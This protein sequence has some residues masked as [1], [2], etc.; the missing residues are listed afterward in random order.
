MRTEF[1]FLFLFP[2]S[3]V[4]LFVRL[5]DFTE[6]WQRHSPPV[7]QTNSLSCFDCFRCPSQFNWLPHP[8]FAQWR[9]RRLGFT[10]KL[11]QIWEQVW[12]ASIPTK[13]AFRSRVTQYNWIRA[14]LASKHSTQADQLRMAY[15]GLSLVENPWSYPYIIVTARRWYDP[16]LLWVQELFHSPLKLNSM[17]ILSVQSSSK[18][19]NSIVSRRSRDRLQLDNSQYIEWQ[20]WTARKNCTHTWSISAKTKRAC[21]FRSIIFGLGCSKSQS[22]HSAQCHHLGRLAVSVSFSTKI[23]AGMCI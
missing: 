3:T 1:G 19:D 22:W 15:R 10:L 9:I 23:E 18:P 14:L 5:S 6:L 8:G 21:Y 2:R 16:S 20:R 11:S 17:D 4:V 13:R 7:F 12:I